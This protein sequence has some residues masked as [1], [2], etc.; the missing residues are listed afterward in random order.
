MNMKISVIIPIYNQER[1]L[2]E[3]LESVV[4][5][6]LEGLEIILVNDGSTDSS[7][8]ICMEYADKLPNMQYIR[9][10]NQGLGEARN[11]GL[12]AA[13]GEYV[14]FL[15]ADDEIESNCLKKLYDFA[16]EN[17][18]DIVY[19]DEM[20]CDSELHKIGVRRTYSEMSVDIDKLTALREALQ[21]AH[22]WARLYRKD[23]VKK[24]RF[25][26]IW[27]EDIEFFPRVLSVADRINYF[28]VPLYHYRQ[29]QQGITHQTGDVRNEQVI[30]AWNSVWNFD[31]YTEEER[32]A[33]E[34]SIKKSISEFVFF[35]KE[36]ADK[37]IK[38][39]MDKF[40]Y[41][42]EAVKVTNDTE[43]I[44]IHT[45]PIWTQ[46]E[47]YKDTYLLNVLECFQKLYIEGGCLMSNSGQFQWTSSKN[48]ISKLV[49]DKDLNILF[50]CV[51]KG[52]RAVYRIL[53]SLV[54]Q[55]LISLKGEMKDISL[56]R[57]ALYSFIADNMIVEL[58]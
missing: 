20:I 22:V 5:Q 52:S 41:R 31:R 36:F 49:L 54:Q 32:N 51:P 27:Y 15:D 19:F 23:L 26:S 37:Y 17:N 56:N 11:T 10:Q 21:P 55:N 18:S 8:Q 16:E 58:Q 42:K 3:C 6:D 53:K 28:K 33:L 12:N 45:C 30:Q 40:A 50:I 57:E 4:S 1:Y 2:A 39:Y 44:D 29:Q 35:R 48:N 46:A 24:F 13:N 34:I 9:K 7:E 47:Y 14:F 25:I 43:S 38:F